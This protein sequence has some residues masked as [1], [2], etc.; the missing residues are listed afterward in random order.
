MYMISDYIKFRNMMRGRLGH[1]SRKK[2]CI[3]I[4]QVQAISSLPVGAEGRVPGARRLT[5]ARPRSTRPSRGVA[6]GSAQARRAVESSANDRRRKMQ[7]GEA[8]TER[9]RCTEPRLLLVSR[10]QF[11]Q[12]QGFQRIG[13]RQLNGHR[14]QSFTVRD[15]FAPY[16][17]RPKVS[18]R[19]LR[20]AFVLLPHRWSEATYKLEQSR[21]L[22][23][24]LRLRA[25]AP[26]ASAST[27]A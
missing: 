13:R 9:L 19:I 4:M 15:C 5:R 1:S 14:V 22:G 25:I 24:L 2:A 12:C 23:A 10:W 6:E 21:L 18:S 20:F 3:G 27:T 17:L 7:S 8:P 26:A 11:Q 16:S